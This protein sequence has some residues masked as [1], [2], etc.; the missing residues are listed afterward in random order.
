ME[1]PK[2]YKNLNKYALTPKLVRRL[3]PDRAKIT[4][5][6]F[7]RNDVIDAWCISGNTAKSSDDEIYGSYDEYWLGVYDTDAKAYAGKVRFYFTCWGGMGSYN[8]T[9]FLNPKEIQNSDDLMVQVKF[10][11]VINS[12]IENGTLSLPV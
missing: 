6:P 2:Q 4:E 12:L 11:T 9:S 3:V 7:W 8:I 10:L 5:K 1:I